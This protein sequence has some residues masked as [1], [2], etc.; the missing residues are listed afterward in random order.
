MYV[1]GHKRLETTAKYVHG[2]LNAARR[3]LEEVGG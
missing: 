3:L 2:G 1:L